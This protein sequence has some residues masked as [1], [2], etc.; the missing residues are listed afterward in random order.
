MGLRYWNEVDEEG[1]SSWV[2]ECR[3]VSR[4]FPGAMD[5]CH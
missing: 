5:E 2:F 4:T 1:E 3:D